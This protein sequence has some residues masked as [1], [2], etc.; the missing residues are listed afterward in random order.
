M[1][2]KQGSPLSLHSK[3]R[4]KKTTILFCCCYAIS[5][6]ALTPPPHP[7]FNKSRLDLSGWSQGILRNMEI[8][9]SNRSNKLW[10]NVFKSILTCI[11][12]K[13]IKLRGAGFIRLI[14]E[15]Q[16]Q[17]QAFSL[18]LSLFLF[19]AVCPCVQNLSPLLFCRI[20]VCVSHVRWGLLALNLSLPSYATLEQTTQ[21]TPTSSKW[22]SPC[23]T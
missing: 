6:A 15:L 2:F 4:Q 5:N 23:L 19:A 12:I 3:K 10:E 13:P 22:L 17:S 16:M 9:L 21:N 18:S 11:T 8:G 14:N 20:K 7:E 1:C